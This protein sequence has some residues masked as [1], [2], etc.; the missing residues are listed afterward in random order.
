MKTSLTI[1]GHADSEAFLEAAILAPVSVEPDDETLAITKASVFNLFLN[2]PPEEA[3]FIV[4]GR[5]KK[6]RNIV[7]HHHTKDCGV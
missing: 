3:L 5:G 2:T 6:K 4:E 1:S 7:I